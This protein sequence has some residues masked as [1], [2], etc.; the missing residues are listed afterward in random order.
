MEVQKYKRD[1]ILIGLLNM[2]AKLHETDNLQS[3]LTN[4]VIICVVK[5]YKGFM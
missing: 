2:L 5:K 3:Y 4:Y 1:P